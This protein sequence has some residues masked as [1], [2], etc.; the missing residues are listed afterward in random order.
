ME[1][2]GFL[3][4]IREFL[5][6]RSI[7]VQDAG[8]RIWN[9]FEQSQRR[10]AIRTSVILGIEIGFIVFLILLGV[11]LINK[12]TAEKKRDSAKQTAMDGITASEISIPEQIE[13][14]A[15]LRD[16]GILSEAEFAE[17]KKELLS[18]L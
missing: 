8:Q 1:V 11:Y 4:S 12:R 15:K 14:L 13:Q 2:R 16:K 6:L 9:D 18:K 7:S 17:K 3:I 5:I 10:E